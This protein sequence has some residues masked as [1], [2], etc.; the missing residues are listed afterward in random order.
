MA[1]ICRLKTSTLGKT[2]PRRGVVLKV[3][4][5]IADVLWNGRKTAET[6]FL[7]EL[8]IYPAGKKKLPVSRS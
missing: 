2:R 5:G 6:C 4:K 8:E 1:T 3:R 7:S